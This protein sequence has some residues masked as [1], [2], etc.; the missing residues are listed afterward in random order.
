MRLSLNPFGAEGIVVVCQ[1]IS[2][3]KA[4]YYAL[5]IYKPLP[6]I[7]TV[8][9]TEIAQMVMILMIDYIIR[10]RDYS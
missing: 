4:I 8:V 9:K 5:S 1:P 6:M 10:E 2:L 7:R 3:H